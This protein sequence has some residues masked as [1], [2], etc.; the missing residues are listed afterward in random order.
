MSFMSWLSGFSYCNSFRFSAS[1][2]K[3][4]FLPWQRRNFFSYENICQWIT[5]DVDY[6]S[7]CIQVFGMITINEMLRSCNSVG[8]VAQRHGGGVDNRAS[9]QLQILMPDCRHDC[10]CT[11]TYIRSWCMHPLYVD[12]RTRTK[13]CTPKIKFLHISNSYQN[14]QPNFLSNPEIFLILNPSLQTQIR[15]DRLVYRQMDRE[16]NHKPLDSNRHELADARTL[17]S[18]KKL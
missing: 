3:I 2:L 5:N 18:Y 16:M 7:H 6:Q 10:T 14:L 15:A 8:T 17:K 1:D 11:S 12:I 13:L 4:I 9:V